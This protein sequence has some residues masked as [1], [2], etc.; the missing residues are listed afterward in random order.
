MIMFARFLTVATFALVCTGLRAQEPAPMA[1]G[2]VHLVKEGE[3][4]AAIAKQQLGDEGAAAELA[5]FNSLA[6]DA[7]LRAG[8]PVVL[9]GPE[10]AQAVTAIEQARLAMQK[11]ADAKAGEFSMEEFKRAVTLLESASQSRTAAIYPRAFAVAKMAENEFLNSI[12]VAGLK[13]Q[14]SKPARIESAGG[15]VEIRAADGK[16]YAPVK[17]GA[18]APAGTVLRTSTDSRAVVALPDGSRIALQPGAELL[19]ATLNVDRRDG[20]TTSRL[21]LL[22]GGLTGRTPAAK[23]R[24]SS[25]VVT[26]GTLAV[27]GAD[28]EFRLNRLEDG[29]AQVLAVRNAL[30]IES[31]GR[32]MELAAGAGVLANAAGA[33]KG[34]FNAPGPAAWTQP[35]ATSLTTAKQVLDLAW[36]LNGAPEGTVS[37]FELARDEAFVDIVEQKKLDAAK[38]RVGPLADGV[39]FARVTGVAGGWLAGVSS[40][41]LRIEV[42]TNLAVAFSADKNDVRK[43]GK[44]VVGLNAAVS[45]TPGAGDTSVVAVEYS[46]DGGAFQKSEGG[47]SFDKVGEFKLT[48]RGVAADGKAGEAATETVIVDGAAPEVRV[49]IGEVMDFP[50]YGLVRSVSVLVDD[51]I[52]LG[53]V[54]VALNDGD[55]KKYD[56]PLKLPVGKDHRVRVRAFDAFGNQAETAFLLEKIAG[57]S[58]AEPEPTPEKA[59]PAPEKRRG[60]F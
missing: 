43:N 9:P 8:D 49:H 19:L 21:A 30:R 60:W 29:S 1:E 40:P 51:E 55:Y 11:A 47:V 24:N 50:G 2:S 31:E 10:R 39:Y 12:R 58:A 7:A 46:I 56:S 3:T 33:V 18:E 54:E 41:V 13:A 37:S 5:A 48:A 25:L 57:K 28:A 35:D 23:T 45:A 34:P 27:S 14:E 59:K 22:A 17:T 53:K 44:R 52:K 15:K 36:R 26:N 42:K 32:V 20:T 4:L 6:V 16:D 38:V